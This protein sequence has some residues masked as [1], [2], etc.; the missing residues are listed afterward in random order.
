MFNRE[1]PFNTVLSSTPLHFIFLIKFA[2]TYL[3]IVSA[4]ISIYTDEVQNRHDIVS[5]VLKHRRGKRS[6]RYR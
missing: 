6:C 2:N 1:F 5:H 3:L 4:Q